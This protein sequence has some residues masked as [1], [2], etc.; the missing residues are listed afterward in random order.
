MKEVREVLR[1]SKGC[2]IH[3]I[4]KSGLV[5]EDLVLRMI[6]NSIYWIFIRLNS[7]NEVLIVM[8]I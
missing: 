4:I 2:K 6:E 1:N 8:N 7:H 3:A 5:R